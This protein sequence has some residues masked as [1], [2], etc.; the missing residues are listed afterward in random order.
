M[1]TLTVESVLVDVPIHSLLPILVDDSLDVVLVLLTLLSLL[2]LSEHLDV[3]VLLL[4]RLDNEVVTDVALL[5][6]LRRRTFC[7]KIWLKRCD[8]P[9]YFRGCWG[10]WK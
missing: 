8:F 3:P 7:L 10:C 6:F 2:L 1:V 9:D 4:V 5:V